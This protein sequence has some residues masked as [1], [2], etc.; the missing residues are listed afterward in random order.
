MTALPRGLTIRRDAG[1]YGYERALRRRPDFLEVHNNLGNAYRGK[2][3]FEKA[4][5][6][7]QKALS[8]H[9]VEALK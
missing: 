2:G 1:L 9:P 7:Y 3:D 4:V 5:E 8:I 6:C